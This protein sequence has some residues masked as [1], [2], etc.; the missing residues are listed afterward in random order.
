MGLGSTPHSHP[1]IQADGG[2]MAAL[3]IEIQLADRNRMKVHLV[4]IY[5]PSLDV[6]YITSAHNP[7]AVLSHMAPT[8]S[9]G[10]WET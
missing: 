4:G 7:L 3:G 9:R 1:G 6:A 8:N 5:G 10:G 2:S